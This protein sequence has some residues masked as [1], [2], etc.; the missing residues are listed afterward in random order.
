MWLMWARPPGDTVARAHRGEAFINRRATRSRVADENLRDLRSTVISEPC[1]FHPSRSVVQL[2]VCLRRSPWTCR[3]GH[4]PLDSVATAIFFVRNDTAPGS[5]RQYFDGS[6]PGRAEGL[7]AFSSGASR[8]SIRTCIRFRNA[9]CQ[10]RNTL[11]NKM[12]V[13]DLPDRYN[14]AADLLE[15]NL[16]AG[17]A[18]KV[19]IHS[20]TG[21]VTYGDLHKLVCRAARA[22]L[23]LGVR[24]E[25]RVLIAGYDSPGWVAPFLG[26]IPIRP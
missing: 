1:A 20:A 18:P 4:E 12:A 10:F 15:R 22:L 16:V 8:P 5:E 25:E 23:D 6:A 7:G 3:D 19:A 21:D 26:A 13:V 2:P 14:V 24:R 9:A 11:L 17:R